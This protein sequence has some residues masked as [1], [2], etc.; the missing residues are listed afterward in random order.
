VSVFAVHASSDLEGVVILASPVA[1]DVNG[2][3]PVLVVNS[4]SVEPHKSE[5]VHSVSVGDGVSV[6]MDVDAHLLPADG[7]HSASV[8]PSVGPDVAKASCA[9]VGVESDSDDFGIVNVAVESGADNLHP[10]VVPVSP[11]H[12]EFV[13][14]VASVDGSVVSD[15]HV[16]HFDEGTVV[17]SRPD[18]D[19]TPAV[20]HD[21]SGVEVSVDHDMSV[22]GESHV[23]GSEDGLSS[24]MSGPGGSGVK[25]VEFVSI[26]SVG[27]HFNVSVVGDSHGSV[28]GD[29]DVTAGSSDNGKDGGD[30]EFH[31]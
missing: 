3:S 27:V 31:L 1:H 13:I 24:L 17:V 21:V 12:H 18:V 25:E 14:V 10:G 28:M 15:V 30:G 20:D 7:D 19:L 11:R 16:S 2:G 23:L 29:G 5:L 8:S 22:L 9:L 4:A 26:H 6:S